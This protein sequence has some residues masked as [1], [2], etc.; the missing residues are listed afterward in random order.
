MPTH[1]QLD[2]AE[3][4]GASRAY[5]NAISFLEQHFE[6]PMTRRGRPRELYE[7]AVL[8]IRARFDGHRQKSQRLERDLTDTRD[9][10]ARATRDVHWWIEQTE[11]LD[12][13][14]EVT[15]VQLGVMKQTVRDALRDRDLADSELAQAE[16]RIEE[17]EVE[18]ESLKREI[19]GQKNQSGQELTRPTRR[20]RW[21]LF[22][23]IRSTEPEFQLRH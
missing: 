5:H 11:L 20:A 9:E 6:F 22:G 7:N 13:R 17:L 14:S 8:Q 4:R 3:A 16:L 12:T 18:V 1:M 2:T 21:R 10:M 19:E 23:F 15:D